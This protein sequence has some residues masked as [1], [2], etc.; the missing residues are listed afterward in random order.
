MPGDASL[1]DAALLQQLMAEIS[2]LRKELG[3]AR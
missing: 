3:D 2:R 1:S